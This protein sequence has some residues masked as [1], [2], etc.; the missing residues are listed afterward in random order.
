M[1]QMTQTPRMQITGLKSA[2]QLAADKPHGMRIKYM[3]GCRCDLCRRAN[4]NHQRNRLQAQKQGDWNGIVPAAR[5]REHMAALTVAGVGRRAVVDA[6]GV[7]DTI[8]QQIRNGSRQRI[9]ARTERLILAV[10]TAAA[11]D[12]ARVDGR[13][14]WKR[15]DELLALGYSKAFL[16]RQMGY[17]NPALQFRRD[18][19]TVRNAYQVQVLHERLRHVPAGPTLKLLQAFST[20]G[21]LRGRVEEMLRRRAAE[22][23]Q[24]APDLSVRRD[25]I[26]AS[27]ARLVKLLHAEVIEEEI[28]A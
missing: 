6:S 24:A 4:A 14:T 3:A 28:A 1:H 5:A 12:G 7:P 18:R 2:E 16:A 10:T 22:L 8:L 13:A 20:E 25:Q 15:I 19:V 23:G 27:T 21:F 17:T 11:A 9:R 26:L